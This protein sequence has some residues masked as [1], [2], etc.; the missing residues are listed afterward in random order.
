MF[1]T[2]R[3]LVRVANS[4]IREHVVK[5]IIHPIVGKRSSEWP[6]VR[7]HFLVKSPA[8]AACGGTSL[9]N[10]HHKEPFHLDP[11]LELDPGNLITLCMG[12]PECHLLLG[13][14]DDFKAYNPMIAHHA[15]MVLKDPSK[16][17]KYEEEAKT[18]RKYSLTE[19][20]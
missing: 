6:T 7:K 20:S 12:K 19:G 14:G 8:C 1:E 2:V 15:A 3:H 9:L 11:K 17:A 4:Q 5:G 13:H 16:R 10:V 18:N